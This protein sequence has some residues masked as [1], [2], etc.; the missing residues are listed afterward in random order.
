MFGSKRGFFSA[1]RGSTTS[2]LAGITSVALLIGT[3]ALPAVATEGD[4]SAEPTTAAQS[5]DPAP[6]VTSESTP[7][8][9]RS[10]RSR[11]GACR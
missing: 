2:W 1:E 9:E 5:Q 6:E 3:V 4:P 7:V 8:E 11:R 10:R